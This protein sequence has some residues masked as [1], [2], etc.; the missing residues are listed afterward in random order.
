MIIKC[1]RCNKKID[2]PSN[3][4]ADY[5]IAD[6]TVVRE[7]RE[8]LIALKH[9]Q[10]TLDKRAKMVETESIIDSETH[11]EIGRKLKYPNL[12]IEESEY[13]E[14]AVSSVK[15]ANQTIGE[16][17]VKVKAETREKDIQK[18]GIICPDCYRGTDFV[19]WGIHKK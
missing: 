4:N 10:A 9:N 7:P 13:D 16:D 2:T 5:V 6:D 15:E 17:L 8:T 19:I 11:E 3:S 18:T 1:Y 14:V 12:K